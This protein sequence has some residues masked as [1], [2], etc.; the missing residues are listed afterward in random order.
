MCTG[1][2]SGKGKEGGSLE[3][4]KAKKKGSK[5][6]EL[7]TDATGNEGQE[8]DISGT[9]GA[10]ALA[11]AEAATPARSAEA[12][13]DT[14]QDADGWTQKQ[15]D[16][17]Q[18]ETPLCCPPSPA[19]LHLT[20]A[21]CYTAQRN[22]LWPVAGGYLWVYQSPRSNTTRMDQFNSIELINLLVFY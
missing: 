22:G 8:Q 1:A 14:A 6:M 7:T 19:S 18:V 2:G 3:N 4:A 13:Y 15:K 16:A 12:G 9:P 20:T 21:S 5:A 17:L 11:E 10:V